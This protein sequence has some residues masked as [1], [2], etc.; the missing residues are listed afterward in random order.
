MLGS[1]QFSDDEMSSVLLVS[2]LATW[3]MY[4]HETIIL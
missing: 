4:E 2:L 3:K 1:F